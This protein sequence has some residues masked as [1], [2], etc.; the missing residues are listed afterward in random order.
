MTPAEF[1]FIQ[2]EASA[3]DTPNALARAIRSGG[4]M[5]LAARDDGEVEQLEPETPPAM[6][7][8]GRWPSR[9]EFDAAW[10]SMVADR[11]DMLLEQRAIVLAM[12]GLPPDGL[13][14]HLEIPTVASVPRIH[15]SAP[16]TYMTIQ[17]SVSDQTRIAGY[18]DVIL[19]MMKQLG[20]YYIVFV[21]EEGAV[22][23]LRGTWKEQIFAISAWPTQAAAHDFW[24]SDRYQTVA[25]PIRAPIST[26]HVHL[27]Q[28]SASAR[29]S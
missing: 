20:A 29:T 17:G 9:A 24:C 15:D 7:V 13:P 25:V 27:L 21:I 11:V 1:L 26:F 2:A 16:P 14:D 3:P 12:S 8:L 23:V 5:A 19:P 22:R 6:I 4:G 18:R 10:T 28:G